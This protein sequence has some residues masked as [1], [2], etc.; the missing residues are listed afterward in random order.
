MRI[1]NYW[2][3]KQAHLVWIASIINIGLGIIIPDFD[4]FSKS[5]SY[6]ALEAPVFAFTH[7]AAD[8]I[9][10]LSMCGFAFGIHQT[11][12]SR[13]SAATLSAFL[14]GISMIGAG[15]WTLETPL[16]LMYNLSIFMIIVP[17]AFAL[18]FKNIVKSGLFESFSVGVT[19]L[20]VFMFWLI[21]AG[22]IPQELDGLIQR[23]WAVPT[24]GWFGVA[25][26]ML[27]LHQFSVN[28]SIQPTAHASA[29]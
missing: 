25:A 1:L 22:F 9:I 26:H 10:G 29:G 16:H 5:I 13:L 8:I 23:L 24:M 27:I 2:L 4:F 11:S 7:R 19:V 18:E 6:V 28:K 20:H 14:F 15:I 17:M 21:Y 3:I 12:Q